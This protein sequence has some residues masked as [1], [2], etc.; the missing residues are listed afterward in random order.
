MQNSQI[1]KGSVHTGN[2]AE[3]RQIGGSARGYQPDFT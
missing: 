2:G 3:N 1:R